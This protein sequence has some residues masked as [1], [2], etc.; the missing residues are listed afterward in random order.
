ML[1]QETVKVPEGTATAG[2]VSAVL[3]A[4]KLF[5]RRYGKKRDT[6][7]VTL[8]T[9]I[10]ADLS[11]VQ[12]DVTLVKWHVI[13]PTGEGGLIKDVDVLKSQIAAIPVHPADMPPKQR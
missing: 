9:K 3:L 6:H 4:F 12:K 11:E 13:G 1:I 10:Q 5:D 2:I 7:S 8:L